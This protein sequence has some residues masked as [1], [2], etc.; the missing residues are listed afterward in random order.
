MTDGM[1]DTIFVMP[2]QHEYMYDCIKNMSHFKHKINRKEIV[3]FLSE[4]FD[5]KTVCSIKDVMQCE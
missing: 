3:T 4:A 1:F 5:Q 2:F